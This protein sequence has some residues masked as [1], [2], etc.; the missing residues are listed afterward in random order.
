LT[1]GGSLRETLDA[2]TGH[3]VEVVGVAVLVDRSGGTVETGV[4]ITALAT[5]AVQTWDPANCPLC[6][7]GV[8]LVKPGTTPGI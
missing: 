7:L 2:L 1:T 3:D 8:P 5:I 6:E 4:P